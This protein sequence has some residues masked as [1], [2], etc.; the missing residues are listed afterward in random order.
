MGEN[1][2]AILVRIAKAT[3][4]AI[5]KQALIKSSHISDTSHENG[6][7]YIAYRLQAAPQ[8]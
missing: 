4:T 1:G 2:W 3:P 8:F 5:V 7:P 6:T